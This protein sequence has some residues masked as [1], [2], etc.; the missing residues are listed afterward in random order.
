M[1]NYETDRLAA[2]E[3]GQA[4]LVEEIVRHAKGTQRVLLDLNGSSAW[5][6]RRLARSNSSVLVP[7]APDMNSVLSIQGV[8]R[9]FAGAQDGEGRPISLYYVLN[10]F[11]ASLPLHLDVREVLRQ[12]LGNRLLPVM[13]RRS[14]SVSEALAEG[15][16]VIDYA[17]ESPVTEDYTHLAEWVRNLA[18]PASTGLRSIRWSER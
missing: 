16:T 3:A 1:V 4:H 7:I 6:A 9:F 13:I 10:Q 15:M 14:Q 12:Q 18:A 8:E 17:P 2:D 11:D 5:L